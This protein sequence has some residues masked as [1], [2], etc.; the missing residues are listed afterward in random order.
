MKILV[1]LTAISLAGSVSAEPAQDPN[2]AQAKAIVQEFSMNLKG[3]LQSAMREGGPVEAISVC[4]E[5]APAIARSLSE[6]TG[7]EVGRTSRKLRNP[8][9]NAPDAWE[10]QVL[11]E[12]EERK[13]AGEDVRT[14]AYAEVL[15]AAGGTRYRFMKAIPTGELC[16]VCHG[17]TIDS[18]IAAALDAAYPQD[19]ARGFALGDI[20]GAFTLSK[21][22]D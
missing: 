16:L 14:M 13:V 4:K 19:Q 1:V 12:F 9:L 2:A 3:E 21:P 5:R 20:R 15:D 10:E 8:E 17:A 22:L 11:L 7:W 6:S 18:E